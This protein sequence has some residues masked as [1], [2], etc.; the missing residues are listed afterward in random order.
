M[1]SLFKSLYVNSSTQL[2]AQVLATALNVYAST[3]S[4]GGNTATSYGFTV[5]ADGLGDGYVNVGNDGQAF[6]VAN[7]S[8]ASVW[9]LLLAVNSASS[10]GQLYNGNSSLRSQACDLFTNLNNL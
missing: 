8:L 7:N 9:N 3:T 5:T 6:G 2:D 1:A 4:L 10:N